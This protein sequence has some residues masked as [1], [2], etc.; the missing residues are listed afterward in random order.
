MPIFKGRV[1]IRRM[2]S[3]SRLKRDLSIQRMALVALVGCVSNFKVIH[4]CCLCALQMVIAKYCRWL[5]NRFFV[6]KRY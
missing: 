2:P 5:S 1:I 4:F 6:V 3:A